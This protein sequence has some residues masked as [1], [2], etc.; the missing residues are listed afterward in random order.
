MCCS[1]DKVPS[2]RCVNVTRLD[3]IYLNLTINSAQDPFSVTL[4]VSFRNLTPTI[5]AMDVAGGA[6]ST[7]PDCR[8]YILFR[9]KKRR[10]NKLASL[11]ISVTWPV[12]T[13]LFS[14]SCN[15]ARRALF[16][17]RCCEPILRNDS[18]SKIDLRGVC[19]R[20][21][22]DRAYPSGPTW[23]TGNQPLGESFLTL[24]SPSYN[25]LCVVI[26]CSAKYI[27]GVEYKD[28]CDLRTQVRY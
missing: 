23:A 2:A 19:L 13:R 27:Q 1:Q 7:V 16:P 3:Y 21:N 18:S 15:A 25:M 14:D 9:I 17:L 11:P 20:N 26:C 28:R 24:H 4:N 12:V 8:P 6:G 5:A 22:D 10:P